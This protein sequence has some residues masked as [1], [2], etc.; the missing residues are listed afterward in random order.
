VEAETETRFGN[1]RK[2]LQL[3][4]HAEEIYQREEPRPSPPW[5]DWFS[6]VRLAGF[7]GNT[8]L[9]ARQPGQAR[10]T[11]QHVLDN[12]PEDAIKQRSVILGDL[13]AVAVSEGKAEEGCRLAEM[14]LDHLSRNWYATGM[15]RVRAVRES[16]SQ[17]E[18][19]PAVRRLDEKLYD[20]S[21]T[22]NALTGG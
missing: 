16:L 10:E 18:S 6:P 12:L 8:L 20:W 3:I 14:A 21:T 5:L 7:K 22:L 19:L 15:A 4:S 2:A 1:T 17:W 9:A 11:L 13:A